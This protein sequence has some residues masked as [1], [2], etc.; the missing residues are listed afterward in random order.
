MSL[1]F[2]GCREKY[3]KFTDYSFDYFDT[4][5]SI[6]GFEKD[7]SVFKANCEKIK[8][9]LGEYHKLYT[10]YSRYDGVNNLYSINTAHTPLEVDG[11]ITEMLQFSKEMYDLT[12]GKVNVAMGSVLS[13][14]HNYRTQ[15]ID[16]P[17]EAR[18]PDMDILREAA[19]HTDIKGLEIKGNTVSLTDPESRLDVGAI[20]KGYATEQIALWMEKEGI[21][22]Y[23]LNVG[24]NIRTVGNRPDG[25]KWQIGLENPNGE[26]S[27]KYSE[28]LELTDSAIV[29]SGS[30]QRFYTVQGK[31][32]HHIID[33]ETLMP[34]KGYK[35]VSVINPSSAVADAL[36]TALFC[37]DL[38]DGKK[39]VE[40]LENTEVLW[41]TED[42]KKHYSKNFKDYIK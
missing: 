15:G 33:P 4:A 39:F 17:L 3:E 36:S 6:I 10:I 21:T 34:A 42:G 12:G 20:A 35:M 31:E 16:N 1:T 13:I 11:K 18:L 19:K 38:N 28:Y 29:T 23:L 9:K 30:Y 5:T 7:E 14:W 26:E 32:Y 8:A 40:S 37:M 24:G 41:I 25:K 2:T 27:K 22:G